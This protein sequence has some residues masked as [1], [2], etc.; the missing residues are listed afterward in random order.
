MLK[1]LHGRLRPMG[2]SDILDEAFELYKINFVLL[3]GTAG[4]VYIPY[5]VISGLIRG[6][7][8][9]APGGSPADLAVTM[10]VAIVIGSIVTG[11]LTFAISDRYLERAT[12][13]GGAYSRALSRPVLSRLLGAVLVKNAIVFGPLIAAVV[14]EVI[15]TPVILA[16]SGAGPAFTSALVLLGSMTVAFVWML[17]FWPRFALV[18]QSVIL[19]GCGALGSLSR[20]WTL[21]KGSVGKA[22]WLLVIVALL[23][24]L[25]VGII[26]GPTG[27]LILA[28]SF[29]QEEIGRSLIV[30]H[31][32]LTAL[33]ESLVAP[34]SSIAVILLYYDMRIRKEGFDLELLAKELDD[35]ARDFASRSA[36]SL[37][38]E[39]PPTD[40]PQQDL[41]RDG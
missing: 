20:S 15:M 6:A 17:C 33:V 13:V 2:I 8:Q 34:L 10:G 39:L 14:A 16:H 36:S 21:I 3:V 26:S 9:F 23:M 35:R 5:L 19:E 7:Q 12:S 29:R 4:A 40:P 11:A 37:P 28:R 18:E 25:I 1:D 30:M 24:L 27:G 32:I 31:T 41:E 22:F 38:R